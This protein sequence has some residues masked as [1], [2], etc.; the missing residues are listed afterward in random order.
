MSS[1]SNKSILSCRS[2]YCLSVTYELYCNMSQAPTWL[3]GPI[4]NCRLQWGARRGQRV[5]E[6]PIC[7]IPLLTGETSGFCCG[8]KGSKF[9]DVPC[10]P[11][12]PVEFNVFLNDPRIS[13]LSRILNLVYS[14]A[15][16]ET[17]QPFPH[18]VGGPSFVC[19]QGKVYHRI[20]PSHRD[21]AVRWLLH[22]GFMQHKS[23]HPQWA[24]TLPDVWKTAF[25]SALER[26]NPFVHQLRNLNKVTDDMPHM[27]LVLHDSGSSAEIAAVMC[28]ENTSR[29]QARPRQ[30][31]IS[32]WDNTNVHIPTVS[33][34]WEPLAYPLLFPHATLGWGLSDSQGDDYAQIHCTQLWYYRAR[35]L[36]EPRFH[37]FGRLT[38]EYIVDMFSRDLETRL[39]FIRQNQNRTMDEDAALM[40][41]NDLLPSENVYLP[42]SFLGSRRWSSEQVADSLTIATQ[43]GNPTFFITMTCNPESPEIT[44]QLLPGQC[45]ADV[46]VVVCRVFKQK[47][48]LLLQALKT[49]FPNAG[50]LLYCIHCV[51][52][53][54][55][56]LPHAHIL[57][58]YK[59]DCNTTTDIDTVVSAEM[60]DNA[61]DAAL[62]RKFMTH[63]HPSS[64]AAPS[65][66]CQRVAPD[67]TRYCRFGYPF[68]LQ[69]ATTIN[70]DGRIRYRR[71]KEGDEMIVPHCL[72]ILRKFQ[73]HINF[74]VA[75]TA[76]LFQYIFKYIHK[77]EYIDHRSPTLLKLS[78]RPR[79]YEIPNQIF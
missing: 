65:K 26:I 58:K 50:R 28:Y 79:Y 66:Y 70:D 51:E 7:H 74:E 16:L 78:T 30:L 59:H 45:F 41:V 2:I 48:H 29:T 22:D 77:G 21:S 47:L 24:D 44:Q 8:P 37:I 34:M 57:V 23:P 33:R 49:M 31:L 9:R 54:K 63:N 69:N 71:R 17:T 11:P 4:A 3:I 64:S 39:D 25:R 56:G 36:R 20:R 15:S 6:C 67:G 19:I 61:N 42:S 43:K 60:P 27:Q 38:N 55:R 52:F 12:L 76:H 62:V 46:P 40:G 13:D 5:H 10:L 1:F 35:L 75:S 72:P 68:P 18:P 53:Q 73:C 32:K 14:F